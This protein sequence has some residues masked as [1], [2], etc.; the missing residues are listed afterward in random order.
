MQEH[1]DYVWQNFIAKSKTE[2]ATRCAAE[3][4]AVVAHSAGG[5]CVAGLTEKFKA[6]FLDRVQALVFTDASYHAMFKQAWTRPQLERLGD[7]SVH[8][9]AYKT[10]HKDVGVPFKTS[11][12]P[13]TEVSAGTN[14][15]AM[16]TGLATHAALNFI[17]GQFDELLD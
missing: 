4:L 16:T 8:Y 2:S 15:H 3:K 1:C 13:I 12:G 10:E 9:K 6:E 7:I 14:V 5:R 11:N 17:I